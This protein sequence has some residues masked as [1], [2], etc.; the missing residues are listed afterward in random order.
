MTAAP[1]GCPLRARVVPR[2]AGRLGRGG[3]YRLAK[4]RELGRE[5]D[6]VVTVSSMYENTD[7][8]LRLLASRDRAPTLAFTIDGSPGQGA[9]ERLRSFLNYL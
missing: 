4:A 1:G 7:T 9:E 2:V 5:V 8:I 6:G 3:R